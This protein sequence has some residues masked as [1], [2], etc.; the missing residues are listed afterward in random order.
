MHHVLLGKS[1]LFK[2]VSLLLIVRV[3]VRARTLT[4]TLLIDLSFIIV[5]GVVQTVQVREGLLFA[6]LLDQVH[7]KELGAGR[8]GRHVSN[9]VFFELGPQ[10]IILLPSSLLRR[11][12]CV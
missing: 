7:Q 8:N 9:M 3:G 5:G 6:S 1:I 10:F 11:I 12:E 4:W 2:L